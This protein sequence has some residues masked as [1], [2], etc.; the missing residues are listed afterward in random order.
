MPSIRESVPKF[1]NRS[2][3]MGGL[4]PK[5]RRP[6][7]G[8]WVKDREHGQFLGRLFL[9]YRRVT[10][11]RRA[12]SYTQSSCHESRRNHLNKQRILMGYGSSNHRANVHGDA[13]SDQFLR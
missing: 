7:E 6:S 5:I 8:L 12:S 13:L 10:C 2:S 9:S 11:L 3:H 4:F 1:R